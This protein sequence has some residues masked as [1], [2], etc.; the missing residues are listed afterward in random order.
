LA[1]VVDLLKNEGASAE[2]DRWYDHF[3]GTSAT[4]MVDPPGTPDSLD[5]GHS[6]LAS[7]FVKSEM[8]PQGACWQLDCGVVPKGWAD[9]PDGSSCPNVA[10]TA[11]VCPSN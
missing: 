7:T 5:A 10:W 11:D 9:D 4:P 2:I 8:D 1:C 3:C 6:L